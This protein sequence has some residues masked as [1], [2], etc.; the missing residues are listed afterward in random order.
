LHYNLF[1]P[2]ER[3]IIPWLKKNNI[4]HLDIFEITFDTI[5]AD[6]CRRDFGEFDFSTLQSL[7]FSI[8]NNMATESSEEQQNNNLKEFLSLFRRATSSLKH[9]VIQ[10]NNNFNTNNNKQVLTLKRFLSHVPMLKSLEI[11]LICNNN[12]WTLGEGMSHLEKLV[13]RDSSMSG[14]VGNN[15]TFCSNSLRILDLSECINLISIDI[16]DCPSLE[17]LLCRI[18]INIGGVNGSDLVQ[19]YGFSE[20]KIIGNYYLNNTYSYNDNVCLNNNDDD[21]DEVRSVSVIPSNF[22]RNNKSIRIPTDCLI[23]LIKIHDSINTNNTFDNSYGDY[24]YDLY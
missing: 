7:R 16:I 3:H 19:K 10:D 6:L 11:D 20:K 24:D 14:N 1:Y 22:F 5:D 4:L 2:I 13:R 12:S 15:F 18:P 9:L 23:N 21:D 8:E 17:R